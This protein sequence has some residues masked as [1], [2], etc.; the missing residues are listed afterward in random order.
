MVNGT[1]VGAAIICIVA[2]AIFGYASLNYN[3]FIPDSLKT[4]PTSQFY[5]DLPFWLGVFALVFLLGGIVL[6][7]AA[8]AL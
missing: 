1:A 4:P 6:A 2:A 5:I 3:N 7:V 8:V